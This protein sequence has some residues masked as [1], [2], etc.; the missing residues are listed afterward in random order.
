MV[1][2]GLRVWKERKDQLSGQLSGPTINGINSFEIIS[3]II[4]KFNRK[5]DQIMIMFYD[6]C[7]RFVVENSTHQ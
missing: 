7:M 2:D 3:N 6:V 1:Q 5:S 4:L